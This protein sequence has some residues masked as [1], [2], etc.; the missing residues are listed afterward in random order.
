MGEEVVR[1]TCDV[2]S[3]TYC[4]LQCLELK[5]LMAILEQ[6]P[7]YRKKFAEDLQHDLT[8][9]MRE[10][11]EYEVSLILKFCGAG[12]GKGRKAGK[13]RRGGK[14]DEEEKK[15]TFGVQRL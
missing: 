10:G 15:R 8:Y 4:D 14:S 13:R 11:A 1:S 2:K 9:N 7:D 6:Y 5:G 12:R 3:L